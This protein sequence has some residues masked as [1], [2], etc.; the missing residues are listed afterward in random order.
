[1]VSHTV[2]L[3]AYVKRVN[4]IYIYIHFQK[5]LQNIVICFNSW[6]KLLLNGTSSAPVHKHFEMNK[7]MFKIYRTTNTGTSPY[8]DGVTVQQLHFLTEK[9]TYFVS[10]V[11]ISEGSS[12]KKLPYTIIKKKC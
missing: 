3:Q 12:Q 10:F 2:Q 8:M 5:N 7:D 1:M 9:E 4:D 6:R 11:S